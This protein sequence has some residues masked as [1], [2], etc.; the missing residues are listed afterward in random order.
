MGTDFFG[1]KCTSKVS[2]QFSESILCG[3]IRWSK[4]SHAVLLQLLHVPE[5]PES[6]DVSS[7]I[8]IFVVVQKETIKL[9]KEGLKYLFNEFGFSFGNKEEF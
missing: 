6:R 3:H 2:N 9:L 1:L 5:L 7:Y 8:Y 4:L